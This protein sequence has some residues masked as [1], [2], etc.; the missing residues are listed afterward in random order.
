[1]D[2]KILSDLII[3]NLYS[4]SSF[5]HEQGAG[6]ERVNRPSWAVVLKYT[7]ETVYTCRGKKHVSDFCNMALLPKGCSYRWTCTRAGYVYIAEFDC[8]ITSDAVYSFPVGCGD[9]ALQLFRESENR[10]NRRAPF[11]RI[12]AVKNLYSLLLLLAEAGQQTYLPSDMRKKLDP[13]IDYIAKNYNRR[14]Y[15]DELSAVTGLSTVYFRRL[16][17][18]AYGLS[19]AAYIQNLRIGKAK[20]MLKSDYGSITDIALSLGYSDI[21]DFSRVFKRIT[22]VSPTAYAKQI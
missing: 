14:V 7:G 13:A 3:T 18:A 22:G 10:L 21:Y 11:G 16:F 8:D 5:Y 2:D 9:K 17:T 20:D 15:N 12:E 19:P 1:M 4:V 6:A